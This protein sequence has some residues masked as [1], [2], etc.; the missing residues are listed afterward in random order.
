MIVVDFIPPSF[1]TIM[2]LLFHINASFKLILH[3]EN[4]K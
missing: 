2:F 3:I 4:H 1:K